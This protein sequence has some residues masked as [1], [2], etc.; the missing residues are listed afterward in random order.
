MAHPPISQPIPLRRTLKPAVALLAALAWPALLAA[1][2]APPPPP[3]TAAA[4]PVAPVP[5]PTEPAP[6]PQKLEAFVVTG[7]YIPSAETAVEAGPSPVLRIDRLEMA[8]SGINT[9]AE[10]L[11]AVT[12]S[13]ANAVPISNNATGFTPGATSVSLRGLGPEAT[14][15]LINGR[16]VAPYPVGAGGTTAFV[17]LNSIP[18]AA[19]DMIEVLKDGAS[20]LYGADAVA[21]VINLKLRR[22][23]S[24]TE[25]FAS[26]GNTVDK[27]SA[28]TVANVVTGTVS[29]KL[30]LTFGLN[31]YKREAIFN[32]DRNY[33]A[34]A[35]FR[36]TNS[37]PFN[38]EVSRFA[39]A[40]ALGQP[41]NAPLPGVPNAAVFFAQSGADASNN[42]LRPAG[43]YVYSFG[44]SSTYNFNESSQSY[45]K[46]QRRG[47]FLFGERKILGTDNI[48]AY[49]D[50]SF[51]EV[52]TNYE[53]AP[54]ATSNFTTPGKS[55]LVIPARTA[56]P[57]LTL[58]APSL[59][60]MQQVP[61]GVLAPAGTIPGPGTRIVNGRVQRIAAAGAFN[62]FNPFNQDI[63]GGSRARLAEFGNRLL[64]FET[65][66]LMIA[67]GIKAE[68]VAGKWNFDL[69]FSHSAIDDK[70]HHRYASATRFNQIVNAGSAL[71]DPRSAAYLGT[72]VPYNP[73]GYYRN[74]IA[75]NAAL[76]DYATIKVS[77]RNESSLGQLSFVGSTAD[78][79]RLPH[80]MLGVAFGGDFRRE[81]LQQFPDAASISGDAV[82]N[83][84]AATTRAQRKIGGVFAE[85]RVPLLP[86][87]EA[88]LSARHEKFFTS[89][90]KVTV[91]K[92]GLRYQPIAQQLTVRASY[93]EGFR[94]PSLY[95]L[96][97]SPI[98]ILSPIIDPRDGFY[99]PEMSVTLR[100]N[101]RLA[102]EE[103]SYVNTGVIWTPTQPR[104]KGLTLGVDWWRI[105]RDGT[106]EAQPQNV[107]YRAFGALPGGL[108][109]D[110]GVFFNANGEI[111]L[112]NAVFYNIGRTEVEGWDFS[113]QYRLPTDALGVWAFRTVWTLMTAY[114][115][116]AAVGAPLRSVLGEDSTGSGENGYLEWKGRVN[117]GWS[118]RN[119][120]VNFA[121]YYTDG[122][123]DADLNGDPFEVD[124]RF[125]VDAQ[126]AYS[127]RGNRGRL[128]RDTKIA[129]GVQNLFDQD[130][131][132]ALGGG[133]NSTGY[134][135]FLYT[136][137]NRSWYLS[138]SRK[139]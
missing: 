70:S 33:S 46:S 6:A 2:A 103:T 74:P 96:Y 135:S 119:F 41:V 8:E 127:F 64:A 43:Q 97:S 101:R 39:V 94:E 9:T 36:T 115:R 90:R 130:P 131:P 55:E 80:G 26:Y 84:P 50:F 17:D 117:L 23:V 86:R 105:E 27:D 110:E 38:L 91:P 21:G 53:L 68:N 12:V 5:V 42:G 67:A 66:A 18:L 106:V 45:P 7:S 93:S 57:I 114:D 109:P 85:A 95:E 112:V 77:D 44:R 111:N 137:E 29:D 20:A 40:A 89:K 104:L 120:D 73:F 10:L 63:A 138:L 11:Q 37:S 100:G 82:G 13:N 121:G 25:T 102:A 108:Q 52:L 32:R 48:K 31:F 56:N 3:E 24:G 122:F 99:E 76:I 47:A 79:L 19:V 88:N 116:S 49:A 4:T 34:V 107:V 136:A 124:D 134:P 62:A 58:I 125:L 75:G 1:Q 51:Q 78:L 28:E 113:G 129:F 71:F 14:L 59:G 81:V 30:N 132:L 72:A 35:P 16:R 87:L 128:L 22:G 69:S 139:F 126:V 15:V 54:S 92:I 98:S 61:A 60:I 83:S 123:E 133:G 118:Y 65:D